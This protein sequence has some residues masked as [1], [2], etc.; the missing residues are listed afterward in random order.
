MYGNIGKFER[1]I[2]ITL[3]IFAIILGLIKVFPEVWAW[4]LIFVG[5][6]ILAT[7]VVGWCGL[8]SVCNIST[9]GS[10][11][12]K[13]SKRDIARA[14]KKNRIEA[15]SN[16]VKTKKVE[17]KKSPAK[18]KVVKKSTPK[19]TVKKSTTKKVVSKKKTTSSKTKK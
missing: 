5:I 8:Y 17:E 7:G 1:V 9:K 14:V 18:K 6:V 11:I 16:I 12:D 2:R 13:I 15:K 4:F 19:K 10:G 3:G